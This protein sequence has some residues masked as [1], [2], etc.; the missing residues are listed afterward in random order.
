M[1]AMPT[2]LAMKLGVSLARTTPLPSTLVTKVSRSSRIFGCVA[3]AFPWV[4]IGIAI[5]GSE[6]EAGGEGP[7]TFVYA[8][9]ATLL[10]LFMSFAV[11]QFRQFRARSRGGRYADPV[12]AE[13]TYLVLSLVAKS[14]LAWQVFAG[15][16]AG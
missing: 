2:R 13:R 9:F 14:A 4:A 6:L 5:A 1:P 3:G 16:L 7:P 15:A 11:V 10:V 8:I 12:V